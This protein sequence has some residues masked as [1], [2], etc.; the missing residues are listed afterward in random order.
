MDKYDDP[1]RYDDIIN[2]PHPEPKTRP[3]ASAN[4]RAA[5]FRGFMPISG[6]EKMIAEVERK[7]EESFE[8]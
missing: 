6:Y 3:R 7:H 5:Q 2:L 8:R 4:K 1:H